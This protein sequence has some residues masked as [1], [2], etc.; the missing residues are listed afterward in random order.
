MWVVGLV[1]L[2]WVFLMFR[3]CIA[4]YKYYQSVKLL[5]PDIWRA[6]GSPKHVNIPFAFLRPKSMNVLGEISN[7]TVAQCAHKY[8][9]RGFQLLFFTIMV[10]LFSI[11][12][13]KA[14]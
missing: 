5:E 4:E 13:F 11:I 14:Y 8:R 10:L 1:A 2:M 9:K 6:L 3:S 7:E 12:Y